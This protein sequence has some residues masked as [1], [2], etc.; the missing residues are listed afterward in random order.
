MVVPQIN[1]NVGKNSLDK[2][3][4]PVLGAFKG[5]GGIL[6]PKLKHRFRVIV[7][8]FG[9][10]TSV[11]NITKQT[12]SVGRPS[13]NYNETA[14]HSYNNV[15]WIAQKP[16]WQTLELVVRDDIG[17]LATSDVS[18]Q[19]QN[20]MNHYT[21]DQA[22]SAKDYKFQM[23]IQTLDG[24]MGASN[25][26]ESWYLEGCYLTQVAYD[27]LEYSSS[28]AMQITM[29]IR[30]DNALQG[31]EGGLGGFINSIGSVINTGSSI[32]S[33]FSAASRLFGG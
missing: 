29:T 16:E 17:N 14:L 12:V 26:I 2:F 15:I 1:D 5:G 8:N 21:Q 27:S 20:Q 19:V 32:L 23:E 4:V 10:I 28:D 22:P 24:T 18:Q 6:M 7:Y 25:I 11:V 9:K 31:N 30:Y 33:A 13:I 3:G